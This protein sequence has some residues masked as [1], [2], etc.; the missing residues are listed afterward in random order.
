MKN[1]KKNKQ[2]ERTW[3]CG[4]NINSDIAVRYSEYEEIIDAQKKIKADNLI[5]RD[6]KPQHKSYLYCKE[7]LR[8]GIHAE[9]SLFIEL[10]EHDRNYFS[11]WIT[12][13][14]FPNLHLMRFDTKG[15]THKNNFSDIPLRDQSVPTPH[16]HRFEK[17]GT[18][19]AY[20]VEPGQLKYVDE[21]DF[22]F[23]YFC[24]KAKILTMNG[25]IPEV[26]V[27]PRG[28]YNFL[29]GNIDPNENI[30]FA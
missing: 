5:V 30:T 19:R 25:D 28:E 14:S 4:N 9:V 11:T 2:S 13:E 7:P 10:L 18:F 29:N 27:V 17:D 12:S 24:H 26:K 20:P 3:K 1:R 21:F 23:A 22:G 6:E 16:L 15:G 8:L